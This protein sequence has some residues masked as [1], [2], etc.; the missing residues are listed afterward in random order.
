MDS[1]SSDDEEAGAGEGE[2][3]QDN[4]PV[5]SRFLYSQVVKELRKYNQILFSFKSGK[6]EHC[7]PFQKC[8]NMIP[9]GYAFYDAV[10]LFVALP[11]TNSVLKLVV[12]DNGESSIC[13]TRFYFFAALF[14]FPR[15]EVLVEW[16]DGAATLFDNF[17]LANRNKIPHD[18]EHENN[19]YGNAL[20]ACSKSYGVLFRY[21]HVMCFGVCKNNSG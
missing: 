7:D 13:I 12:A 15:M 6:P 3:D 1:E 8:L 2:I 10:A 21:N 4:I 9:I 16:K 20:F 14:C 5:Y 17:L 19:I 18:F 11:C